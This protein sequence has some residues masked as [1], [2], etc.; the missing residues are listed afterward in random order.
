MQMEGGFGLI[1]IE[2]VTKTYKS[3]KGIFDVSFSIQ[4]GEVFGYLGPNGAGKTTT[5]RVLMGFLKADQGNC[6]IDGL[7]C[8]TEQEKIQRDV[9]YIPGEI[10]FFQDMTGREFLSLMNALRGTKAQK[11]EKELLDRFDLDPSGK[12][13]R[14]SKGMK[15]KLGVVTAFMH[16]PKVYVL[17]EPTSGLDPLMQNEFIH[18]VHEEKKRG[19]TFLM[20]S[21][22]FTEA[23]R[24]SDRAGIIREGKIMDV[25]DVRSLKA[26]QKKVYLVSVAEDKD[27]ERMKD[28]SLE[29]GRISDHMIEIHVKDNYDE[30]L[31][32][33]SQCRVLGID[34]MA[35]GLEEAF[36]RYYGEVEE[37]HEHSTIQS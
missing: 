28:S 34:V 35:Q 1:R 3:G 6:S 24:T 22:N 33:L 9:G 23:D 16:D 20:S 14:M 8:W 7:D 31:S 27:V 37:H 17:D 29:I 13:K 25:E 2:N 15:Q 26:R 4:T 12:I 19:K 36:L 10:A 11:R 32:E 5:I 21:H 30:F 18:L